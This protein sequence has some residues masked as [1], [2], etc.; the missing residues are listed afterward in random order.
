LYFAIVF[1]GVLHGVSALKVLLIL[2]TNYS[3]VTRL[4]KNLVPVATWTFNIAILFAKELCKGYPLAS[5]ADFVLPWTGSPEKGI[6]KG[7]QLKNRGAQIDSIGGIVPRWEIVFNLTVL[8]LI[9]F[10]LDYYWSWEKRG[11]SPIEV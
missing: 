11:A 8:R 2:Y 7:A 9:S 10:N 3:L 6:E 4:P 1:L 5:I